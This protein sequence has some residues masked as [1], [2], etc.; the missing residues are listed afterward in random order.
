MM[1]HIDALVAFC[2]VLLLTSLLVTVITQMVVSVLNLRGRNLLWGLNRLLNELHP[3]SNGEAE[4]IVKKVLT[5]PLISK[6]KNRLASV[7]RVE[8]LSQLLIGCG[9]SKKT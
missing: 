8:E 2:V 1:N 3:S 9:K 5:Y 6:S 7:I 4:E